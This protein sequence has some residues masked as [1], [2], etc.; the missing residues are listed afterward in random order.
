MVMM[1]VVVV[2]LGLNCK[3]NIRLYIE[4]GSFYHPLNDI[5]TT[6]GVKIQLHI[7]KPFFF[8]FILLQ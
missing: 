7:L 5:T 8:Y 2:G 6:S 3:K 1:M 4:Q